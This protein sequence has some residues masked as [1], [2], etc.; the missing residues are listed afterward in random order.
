[1][2]TTTVDHETHIVMP[3]AKSMTFC[4]KSYEK[5]SEVSSMVT[6]NKCKTMFRAKAKLDTISILGG[7]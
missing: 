4:G 6:C 7:K 2:Q 5:A 3:H 1:M